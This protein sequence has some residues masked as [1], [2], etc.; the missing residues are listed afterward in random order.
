MGTRTLDLILEA[1]DAGDKDKAKEL[2]KL[3]GYKRYHQGD[4]RPS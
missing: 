2:C 1:I 4:R 3:D